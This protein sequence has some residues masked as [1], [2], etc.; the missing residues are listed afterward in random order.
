MIFLFLGDMDSRETQNSFYLILMIFTLDRD[1][2]KSKV[3]NSEI[4]ENIKI[5]SN[6][7]GYSSIPGFSRDM[8]F[9][10]FYSFYRAGQELLRAKYNR[11]HY[12]TMHL[13]KRT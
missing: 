9:S 1:R 3:K 6:M 13:N 7:I 11:T 10:G 12:K 5:S 8:R 4:S 2:R